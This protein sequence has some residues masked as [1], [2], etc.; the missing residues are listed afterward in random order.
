MVLDSI[1]S[2]ANI[3][4]KIRMIRGNGGNHTIGGGTW[5]RDWH[6]YILFYLYFC[7]LFC[8]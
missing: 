4:L 3:I 1:L 2:I 5:P 7:F 8:F 6:I